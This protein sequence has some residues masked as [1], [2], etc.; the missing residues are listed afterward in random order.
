[1][2]G[3]ADSSNL[4]QYYS[5]SFIYSTSTLAAIWGFYISGDNFLDFSFKYTN[6]NSIK[7]TST[8]QDNYFGFSI[9][10]PLTYYCSL[11]F[12]YYSSTNQLCYDNCP[13]RTFNDIKT[14][15]CLACR[16]DCYTCDNS[17]S[18][19]T[20]NDQVDHRVFNPSTSSCIPM[21]GFY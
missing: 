15:S 14:L 10:T 2:S 4:L 21:V 13:E 17:L 16:Y 7:L 18:C 3:R 11:A 20:C 5:P 8:N 19:L 9:L 12:P 1:M 6:P